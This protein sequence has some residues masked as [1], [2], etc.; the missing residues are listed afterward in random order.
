MAL[1]GRRAAG[2]GLGTAAT[3]R[4]RRLA[5]LER[6]RRRGDSASSRRQVASRSRPPAGRGRRP[7]RR[8]AGRP[9]RV[10]TRPAVDGVRGAWRGGRRGAAARGPAIRRRCT[11][12]A[13]S[14]PRAAAMRA[15]E[16]V[17]SS[18][19]IRICTGIEPRCR[20]SRPQARSTSSPSVTFANTLHLAERLGVAVEDA[21]RLPARVVA[22]V[23][24]AARRRSR[25]PA[26]R[27]TAPSRSARRRRTSRAPRSSR[28]AVTSANLRATFGASRSSSRATTRSL[29]ETIS[30]V[31]ATPPPRASRAVA[32]VGA[33]LGEGRTARTERA[34]GPRVPGLCTVHTPRAAARRPFR[35]RRSPRTPH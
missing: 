27:R 11:R 12:A 3:P 10:T 30:M 4:R 26:R 13:S 29:P 35:R 33:I 20:I 1:L 6:G 5:R 25:S 28:T 16:V 17:G 18:G 7:R 14:R 21:D 32:R 31:P 15:V 19:G 8:R 22:D 23:A 34:A 2:L 24:R 9:R